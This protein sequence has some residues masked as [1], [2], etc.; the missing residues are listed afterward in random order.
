M[1]VSPIYRNENG[2]ADDTRNPTSNR[3]GDYSMTDEIKK[4]NDPEF[5]ELRTGLFRIKETAVTHS[6]GHVT[7]AAVQDWMEGLR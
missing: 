5:N 4:S 7:M 2:V 6:D 1:T 3:Q